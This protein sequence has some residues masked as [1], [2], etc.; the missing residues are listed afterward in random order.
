MVAPSAVDD[1]TDH[2]TT[3]VVAVRRHWRCEPIRIARVLDE[4]VPAFEQVPAEV[5]AVGRHERQRVDL[6][7]RALADVAD[8]Q[9]AGLAIEAESRHGLRSPVA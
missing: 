9:V 5:R 2:R 4:A 6:L 1:A 8:P 3:E 7:P